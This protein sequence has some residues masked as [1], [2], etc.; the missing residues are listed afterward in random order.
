MWA[1][2]KI[3]LLITFLLLSLSK[4][5]IAVELVFYNW[6][7][8]ISPSVVE[9]FENESGHSIRVLIFDRDNKRDEVIAGNN[10]QE[11]DLVVVDTV[12]TKLFGKNNILLPMGN[13]VPDPLRN[14][15]P[16]W[17]ESCGNFG[18]PY[19]WGTLGIVY[20]KDKVSP[21]PNSWADLVYPKEELQ[22]HISVQLDSIDTLV[23]PLKLLDASMNSENVADLKKAYKA[24]LEQKKSVFTYDYIVTY[25]DKNKNSSNIH[26]A[27]AYSGDQ[28]TLNA[29]E[30]SDPW[31]FVVPSEGT[32]I[33]VDCITILS[34]SKKKKAAA[35]F[36]EFLNRPEIAAKNSEDLWVATPN[37][38][39]KKYLS[40]SILQDRTVYPTQETQL[41]SEFY[42]ILSNDSIRQRN[43]IIKQ[44]EHN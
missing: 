20:R 12:S 23:P 36:I 34:S 6:A 24:L 7:E 26:M 31:S 16:K 2:N 13:L 4:E 11:I 15:A 38:R 30:Q 44:L 28:F 17:K 25:Q 42:R 8:Y 22:G 10:S 19:L 41:K 9:Q 27:L 33:W 3:I 21:P 39:A 29:E 32:S 14:I 43:R 40:E 1:D 37:F 5:V 35:E 18:V